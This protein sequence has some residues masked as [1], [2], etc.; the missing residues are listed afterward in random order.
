MNTQNVC[1]ETE[2]QQRVVTALTQGGKEDTKSMKAYIGNGRYQMV[3]DASSISNYICSW[4][5]RAEI[6][7]SRSGQRNKA[8][9][10]RRENP[11][12]SGRQIYAIVSQVAHNELPREIMGKSKTRQ[13]KRSCWRYHR[14]QWSGRCSL[15]LY[16]SWQWQVESAEAFAVRKT[17]PRP[18]YQQEPSTL[19]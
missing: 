1:L 7:N 18:V 2:S 4:S 8:R 3:A 12:L 10:A 13:N 17:P 19:S 16:P 5:G 15:T 11:R 9:A 14:E 6:D